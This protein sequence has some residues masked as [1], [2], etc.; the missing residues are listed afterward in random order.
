MQARALLPPEGGYS[1]G[2][3]SLAASLGGLF[4]R[5]SMAGRDMRVQ[6]WGLAGHMPPRDKARKAGGTS[7]G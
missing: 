3:T 7:E 5:S 6:I 2:V 1:Y 4:W